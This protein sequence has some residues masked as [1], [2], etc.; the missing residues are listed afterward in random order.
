MIIGIGNPVY[1]F[2]QTPL[3]TTHTRVL[4]GCSTNACLAVRKLGAQAGLVGRIGPDFS[5]QF[6]ADMNRFGI[7]YELY[8]TAETGGFGLIYDETGD[9]TLDVL[10]IADPIE[11]FPVRFKNA[12]FI[13]V[14]PILG[15]VPAPLIRKMAAEFKAP[16]VLDP[17]GMM[18]RIKNGRIDRYRN[19]ELIDV[20]PLFDI[21][22]PN[23]H[24]AKILTGINARQEPEKAVR[25][26]FGLM[27]DGNR[28]PG[29]PPIAIV[30]LAEMGS[31]IFD[32]KKI[33]HI[34]AFATI[35][36]DPTGAG[37]TYAG[38][39][40]FQFNRTPDDLH[41]VGCFASAVASVMVEYTGPDFELT[42][43]LA[44]QRAVTLKQMQ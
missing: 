22:K 28:R 43:E 24:E 23:E 1:D 29:H 5:D 3:V 21:V 44:Q 39:F 4:S 11:E 20:L 12:D 30:T 14:G 9:R 17:Q 19:P 26:L 40:I 18:R 15:E 31:V 42:L 41:Q 2:I 32:G 33:Y 37:D 35:A 13:L 6:K 25:A 38:G 10:G 36:R 34:P 27:T 7:E 16:L 8:P